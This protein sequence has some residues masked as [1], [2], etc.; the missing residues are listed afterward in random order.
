MFKKEP[1]YGLV[2]IFSN[3]KRFERTLTMMFVFYPI[4]VLFLDSKKQV[5]DKKECFMPFTNYTPRK[6]AQYVIELP[7][8]AARQ[9]KIGDVISW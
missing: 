3:E 5:V 1:D 7:K 8:G 9:T 4:D 2:F 6:A